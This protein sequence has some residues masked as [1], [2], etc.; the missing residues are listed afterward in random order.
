MEILKKGVIDAGPL[1]FLQVL[2]FFSIL[3]AIFD[4][5]TAGIRQEKRKLMLEF[6]SDKNIFIAI[7]MLGL[8]N[9]FLRLILPVSSSIVHLNFGLAPQYIFLFILG[10]FSSDNKWFEAVTATKAKLWFGISMAAIL[11]WPLFIIINGNTLPDIEIFLGGPRWQSFLY[12]FWE[13]A[14]SISMPVWVIYLFR[15][16]FDFQNRLLNSVSKSAYTVFIIHPIIIVSL[17]HLLKDMVLNLLVKFLIVGL[18]GI[19]VC[20]LLGFLIRRIRF[21]RNIL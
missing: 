20:F 19:T 3:Y 17:S 6:P 10:I 14:L 21:L 8:T 2:L 5:T 16:K 15:N 9:F 18:A 12:A 7:I 11:L 13:A 1:W 4:I